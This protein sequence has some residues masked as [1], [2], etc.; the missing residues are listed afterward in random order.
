VD[1]DVKIQ[2]SSLRLSGIALIWWESKMQVDIA[3]KGKVISSWD[4]LTNAIKKQLY[5]LAYMKTAMIEW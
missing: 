1:D 2:L 4:R 3:Q 5:P